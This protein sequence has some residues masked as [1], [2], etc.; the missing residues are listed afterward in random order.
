MYSPNND[1]ETVLLIKQD[2]LEA[3]A[4][5]TLLKDQTP[6][7]LGVT[8]K[9][10][11]AIV[12]ASMAGVLYWQ[13]TMGSNDAEK[14][15][16]QKILEMLSAESSNGLINTMAGYVSLEAIAA[17]AKIIF[18]AVL[19]RNPVYQKSIKV[20]N[21]IV[22]G[23][24]TVGGA[25]ITSIIPAIATY[26]VTK[27]NTYQEALSKGENEE[28]ALAEATAKATLMFILVLAGQIEL[29][30]FGMYKFVT[31]ELA[32]IAKA[33]YKN[34][35]QPIV[36]RIRNITPEELATKQRNAELRNILTTKL[37]RLEE[38]LRKTHSNQIIA[39][40][41][42]NG[43]SKQALATLSSLMKR[44]HI[45]DIADASTCTKQALIA[46][47][48]IVIGAG[49]NFGNV[50]YICSGAKTTNWPVSALLDATPIYLGFKAA[51]G[52][53]NQGIEYIFSA[54]VKRALG[55]GLML[56]TAAVGGLLAVDS[57]ETA[58]KLFQN[59]CP[60]DWPKR[61][62]TPVADYITR[63]FNGI[64]TLIA[65][66]FFV[67]L[68]LRLTNSSIRQSEEMGDRVAAFREGIET[69]RRK[70]LMDSLSKQDDKRLDTFGY[71]RDRTTGAL[72]GKLGFLPAANSTDKVEEITSQPEKTDVY[73]AGA[74]AA[75]N[76]YRPVGAFSYTPQ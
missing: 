3:L 12:F 17:A 44:H 68:I 57:G 30:L 74:E 67:K 25:V 10:A 16:A 27:A 43:D 33:I 73:V 45:S 49:V 54:S 19:K 56:T 20:F 76:N 46:G 4:A 14:S 64:W 52:L 36:N 23:V 61:E 75:A 2:V 40:S 38:A 31:T 41:I 32:F 69:T 8:F 6:S 18:N 53:V 51:N 72:I 62:M 28:Q 1:E 29:N 26:N 9:L 24:L 22:K 15:Q 58:R 59:D 50:A 42:F 11:T 63:I 65:L 39:T 47:G 7:K 37:A 5:N 66:V 13:A 60:A 35:F 48:T 34:I 70:P 71:A 55:W 21:T